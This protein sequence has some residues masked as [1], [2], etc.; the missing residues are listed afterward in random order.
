LVNKR[1]YKLTVGLIFTS[2]HK[3][4][5]PVLMIHQKEYQGKCIDLFWKEDGTQNKMLVQQNLT[6]IVASFIDIKNHFIPNT[7]F[8]NFI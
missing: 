4:Q 5:V 1:K 8:M 2:P 3:L 6:T 7:P